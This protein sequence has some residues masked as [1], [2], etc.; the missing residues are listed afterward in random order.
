M[1]CAEFLRSGG[2][3][4]ARMETTPIHHAP[5]PRPW[6]TWVPASSAGLAAVAVIKKRGTLEPTP[7]S[8]SL[9]APNRGS[10]QGAPASTATSAA[11]PSTTAAPVTDVP[12]PRRSTCSENM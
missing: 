12:R 5:K 8:S 3:S 11:T 9:L 7:I 4:W 2:A 1:V 10:S 6:S